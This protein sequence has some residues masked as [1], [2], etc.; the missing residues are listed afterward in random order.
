MTEEINYSEDMA[1]QSL[2]ELDLVQDNDD[3]DDPSMRARIELPCWD[4]LND[5]KIIREVSDIFD[6][7]ELP[8]ENACGKQ[9]SDAGALA[10]YIEAANAE[11]KEYDAK[12]AIVTIRTG[13]A[14]A[15]RK[16]A[17]GRILEAALTQKDFGASAMQTIAKVT[18]MSMSTLYHIRRVAKVLSMKEVYVLGMYDAGWFNI[19]SLAF[20]KD[21]NT[22]EQLI[23]AY[24]S[25]IT[26]WNDAK[27]RDAARTT[28]HHAIQSVQ[29]NN[30]D[31]LAS[32]DPDKLALVTDHS[33][34][35]PEFTE[36]RALLDKL[37]RMFSK[38]SSASVVDE[39]TRILDSYFIMDDIPGADTLNGAIVEQSTIVL[40]KL[41]TLL[42]NLPRL[43]Q[44]VESLTRS[45]P[46]KA[47]E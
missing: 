44:S 36:A 12:S 13:A 20:I 35:A 1:L 41:N 37:G 22:R 6:G 21:G 23:E 8:N 19:R 34:D 45:V 7:F 4:R 25:S 33:E 11:I 29:S 30:Y 27:K 18:G 32:S 39:W 16:W 46:V 28:L 42:D 5:N 9:F 2:P 15:V 38:A 14:I 24:T 47:E 3:V 43:I 26:D 17:M 10:A 40:D 31:E